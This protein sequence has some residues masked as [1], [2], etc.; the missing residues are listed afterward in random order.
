M[1]P[2]KREPRATRVVRRQ[3]DDP[4][5]AHDAIST[6]PPPQDATVD[7]AERAAR[8]EAEARALRE[9]VAALEARLRQAEHEA[10]ER[11]TLLD[12]VFEAVPDALS[13][14]DREGRIVR[15]N[16]YGQQAAEELAGIGGGNEAL[17]E[18]PTV[19]SLQ[20]AASL[21]F[22]VG[23]Q[24]VARALRGETVVDEMVV[25]RPPQHDLH[26]LVSAA[27]LR[28]ADGQ[29]E[30][31]VTVTHDITLLREGERH[32][33]EALDAL[34]AMAETLVATSSTAHRPAGEMSGDTSA[35][36]RSPT[37]MPETDGVA[38]RLAEL[39]RSFLDCNRVTIFVIEQ[40]T[41]IMR[42]M[43][44][45]GLSPEQ[46]RVFWVEQLRLAPRLGEGADPAVTQTLLQGEVVL[47][48]MTRPPYDQ[49][50]NPYNA[51]TV[52]IAP[53]RV[54][55][56][57]VGILALDFGGAA[58]D[59]TLQEV[60]L[61]GAVGQ[62]AA[63]VVERERLLREAAEARASALALHEA[64]RRMD[65]FLSIV[66]HELRTPVT[67]IKANLQVLTRRLA[68][69]ESFGA[70]STA[71]LIGR[72]D[73]QVSRLIRLLD[74]LVDVSRIRAGQLELRPEGINLAALVRDVVEGQRLAHPDRTIRLELHP[75]AE[76]AQ[77]EADPD[78]IGQVLTNYLTNALKYSASDQLVVVS[79]RVEADKQADEGAEEQVW[80][81]VQ[82]WGPGIPPEEQVQVWALFHRVQG[83]EVVSGSGVGLGLG[84][85]ISKTIVERHGGGVGVESVAGKGST[86]W[87]TLPL[88]RDAG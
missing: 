40:A 12:A 44:I 5:D 55:D 10:Q 34:L 80:V 77:V 15:L 81:S 76:D 21:P 82:D 46:E 38:R 3:N 24:P 37:A 33:R 75:A 78:R 60:A 56:H 62:L 26:M 11:S 71:E 72:T 69:P 31:V 4:G 30:G 47:L 36:T 29:V 64:N 85:H 79:L 73:R 74:D 13:I 39:T 8:A 53:M 45:V 41:G 51:R 18:L 84:L 86:F 48:D 20:T 16:A 67:V 35:E 32:T 63:L 87:F 68:R 7:A 1:M 23:E 28:D 42:P 54:A 19:Y 66:S 17:A 61:A 25:H 14:H 27:P 58:H 49:Q 57:L 52:L 70:S 59:Y 65:E 83:I 43:T 50:P 6:S 2:V 9:R 88:A 22:P